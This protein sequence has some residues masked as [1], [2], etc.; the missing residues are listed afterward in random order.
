MKYMSNSSHTGWETKKREGEYLTMPG[1]DK[2]RSS[3]CRCQLS[4]LPETVVSCCEQ[5]GEL[6]H[7]SKGLFESLLSLRRYL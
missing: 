5:A 6:F 1:V 2:E 7:H 4:L 3:V